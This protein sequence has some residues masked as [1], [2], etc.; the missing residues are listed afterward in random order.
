MKI[1][2]KGGEINMG[3]IIINNIEAK[4]CGGIFFSLSNAKLNANNENKKII[5]SKIN[6]SKNGG[7]FCL[8]LENGNF[9]DFSFACQSVSS[10]SLGVI[11]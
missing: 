6:S 5:F 2:T 1:T 3:E 10:L 7:A 11:F 9:V 4:E 8:Y